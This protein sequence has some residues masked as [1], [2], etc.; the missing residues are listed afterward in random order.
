M[1]FCASESCESLRLA[2][3]TLLSEDA[4]APLMSTRTIPRARTGRARMLTKHLIE[5][6]LLTEP[7][8]LDAA[9]GRDVEVVLHELVRRLSDDDLSRI[10]GGFDEARC[11]VDRVPEHRVLHTL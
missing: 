8:Q 10:L 6:H 3:R 7:L 9:E 11:D 1:S 4:Q 5:E 2:A